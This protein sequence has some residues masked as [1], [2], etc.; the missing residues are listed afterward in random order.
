[1]E[2]ARKFTF[3]ESF[4]NAEGAIINPDIEHAREA[5]KQAG[6]D[7]GYAQ[8]KSEIEADTLAMMTFVNL[9]LEE[10]REAQKEAYE[11][12]TGSTVQLVRKI[13]ERILPHMIKMHGDSEVES[14]VDEVLKRLKPTGQV[15]IYVNPALQKATEVRVQEHLSN[16]EAQM[17]IIIKPDE[18]LERTDC[19]VLWDDGGV[20]HIKAEL[21]KQVDSAL[22]RVLSNAPSEPETV[23]EVIQ[24]EETTTGESDV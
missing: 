18:T 10:I 20:E 6:Y 17:N 8:A 16:F 22:D 3:G 5:G 13:I 12:V 11:F 7:E 14:F 2:A 19:R 15:T 21:L 24:P 4:V 23:N 9:K 1:M